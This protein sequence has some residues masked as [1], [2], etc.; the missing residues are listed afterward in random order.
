MQS[1]SEIVDQPVVRDRE[2]CT[3]VRRTFL[4]HERRYHEY[5]YIPHTNF[6]VSEKFQ[7]LCRACKYVWENQALN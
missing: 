5:S 4:S 6:E 2:H 7:G 1:K 3:V